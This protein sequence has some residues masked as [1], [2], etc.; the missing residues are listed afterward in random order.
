MN[1][2]I[3]GSG[4][5]AIALTLFLRRQGVHPQSIYLDTIQAALP[6]AIAARSLALSQGSVQLLSR[7]GRLPAGET[8][9]RVDIGVLGHGLHSVLSPADIGQQA[10][11]RVVR[12][13]DLWTTLHQALEAEQTACGHRFET[14]AQAAN[15]SACLRIIADGKP[16][17]TASRLA[18]GQVA[19]T[20][21]VTAPPDAALPAP[22]VAYERFKPD[23]P[24][25]LLPLPEPGRLSLVWCMKPDAA[26]ELK[27]TSQSKF[28]TAL[29]RALGTRFAPLALATERFVTPLQRLSQQT[30]DSNTVLRLGNAAQTLHPVAGQGM[31]LGLRDAFETAAL[32][33]ATPASAA[34]AALLVRTALKQRQPDRQS[35]LSLTD[36]LA[37]L[38]SRPSLA[39]LNNSTSQSLAIGLLDAIGPIRRSVANRFVFGRRSAN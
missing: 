25:A 33:G 38:D 3:T 37:R 2:C 32:I 26:S 21:E 8:I 1:I 30:D 18:F 31:N 36:A 23:G 7:L 22:G 5:V 11:G 29:T 4:P 9:E 28:E 27:D 13:R 14:T 39:G 34:D 19:L 17:S 20:C 24:L 10:L 35:T 15:N 16:D 12:Y 6:A